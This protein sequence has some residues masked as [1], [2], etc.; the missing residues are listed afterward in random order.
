MPRAL[1]EAMS[2]GC[3]VV[4]SSVGG[5]PELLEEKM[6]FNHGENER[7]FTIVKTLMQNR[8]E[9]KQVAQH[10]FYEAKKY[11]KHILNHKRRKF[12]LE[13]KESV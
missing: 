9:R 3:P 5:I 6:L 11:Q 2:R 13:F 4:A 7:F 8:E 10:N 12:L 1:I